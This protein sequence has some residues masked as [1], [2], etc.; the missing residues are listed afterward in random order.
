MAS[1]LGHEVFMDE[2]APSIWL[3]E[4]RA[5]DDAQMDILKKHNISGIVSLGCHRE[6]YVFIATN[7]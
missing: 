1:V 6:W 3:G 2:V 4:K 7:I 5:A